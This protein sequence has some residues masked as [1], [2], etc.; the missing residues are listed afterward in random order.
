M[1]DNSTAVP[2]YNYAAATEMVTWYADYVRVYQIQ[3]PFVGEAV[4]SA[5]FAA[6]LSTEAVAMWPDSAATLMRFTGSF[7]KNLAVGV[8]PYPLALWPHP[9]SARRSTPTLSAPHPPTKKRVGHGL[10][11]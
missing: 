6:L 2:T 7:P 9:M 8:A 10:L 4:E 3:P 1:I 11:I 5:P